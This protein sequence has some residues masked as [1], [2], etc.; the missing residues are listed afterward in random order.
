[1]KFRATELQEFPNAFLEFLIKC[2]KLSP[3]IDAE[4]TF[5]QVV[6]PNDYINT[7]RWSLSSEDNQC[8]LKE[9][10]WFSPSLGQGGI[11]QLEFHRNNPCR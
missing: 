1:M 11:N 9:R 3:I 7:G 6:L 2:K 4:Y 10:K 5:K 8:W